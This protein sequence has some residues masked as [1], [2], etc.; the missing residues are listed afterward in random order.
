MMRLHEALRVCQLKTENKE[1]CDLVNKC[2]ICGEERDKGQSKS[3]MMKVM[4]N[5]VT[6]NLNMLSPFMKNG[7][8]SKLNIILVVTIHRSRTKK[9]NTHI[10][11]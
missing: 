9:R 10:N 6:I 1:M 8:V 5:E 4:M 7:V 11:K 2:T 3:V